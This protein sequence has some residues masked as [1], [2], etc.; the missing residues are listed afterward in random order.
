M[1]AEKSRYP[2]EVSAFFVR[3][4]CQQ[5]QPSLPQPQP[6]PQPQPLSDIKRMR[7]RITI[8]V[9][10]HPQPMMMTSFHALQCHHMENDGKW[11]RIFINSL[12]PGQ[13]MVKGGYDMTQK[14]FGGREPYEENNMEVGE[15][16]TPDP[17]S[18]APQR[19]H[20]HLSRTT[21]RTTPGR[22]SKLYKET[23]RN[24]APTR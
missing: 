19:R 23:P 20:V 21:M 2:F 15:E 13:T 1:K 9:L 17:F 16:L 4:R 12:A 7:T 22:R 11:F 8:Q 24:G 3:Y 14:N 6:Q 10:L 18:D 5:P